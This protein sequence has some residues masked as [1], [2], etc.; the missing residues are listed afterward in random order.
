MEA[1]NNQVISKLGLFELG[2]L[3][4]CMLPTLSMLAGLSL[5]MEAWASRVSTVL[6]AL[7]L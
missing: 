6:K 1:L 3:V 4:Y 7:L 2:P 5:M